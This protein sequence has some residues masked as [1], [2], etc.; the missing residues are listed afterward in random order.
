[1]ERA[2]FK[3]NLVNCGP[4]CSLGNM[5]NLQSRGQHEPYMALM[6]IKSCAT[7]ADTSPCVFSQG[8]VCVHCVIVSE[9]RTV[10]ATSCG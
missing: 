7:A 2:A 9:L 8:V 5:S 1:M 6:L 10:T 4:F 3:Y